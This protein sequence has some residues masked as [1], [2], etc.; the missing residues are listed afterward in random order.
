[1]YHR[2]MAMTYAVVYVATFIKTEGIMDSDF[3]DTIPSFSYR[4]K[5]RIGDEFYSYTH[6]FL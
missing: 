3:K 2:H 5:Y 1:M 4:P 6:F